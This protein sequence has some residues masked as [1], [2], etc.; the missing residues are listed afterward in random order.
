VRKWENLRMGG[1]SDR[2]NGGGGGVF[3]FR[4]FE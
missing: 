3:S 2:P 1:G 4:C